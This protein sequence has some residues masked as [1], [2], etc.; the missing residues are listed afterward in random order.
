MTWKEKDIKSFLSITKPFWV[1]SLL[2]PEAEE[3]RSAELYES[4]NDAHLQSDGRIAFLEAMRHRRE[5]LFDA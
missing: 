1:K 3:E 2:S 4:D 5:R